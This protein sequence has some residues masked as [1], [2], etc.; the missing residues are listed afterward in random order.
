MKTYK[1]LVCEIKEEMNNGGKR[2]FSKELFSELSKAYLND[3][4]NTTTVAKTK[5]GE[6]L[7]EEVGVVDDFRKFM[8]KVLIDFGVDKQEASK[9]RTDYEFTNVDALYPVCS[10]LIMNYVDTGKKFTFLPKEDCVASLLLDEY[11]DEV[12]YNKN[13][14][15]PDAAPKATMYKKHRKLKTEST[16]PSWL[17]ELV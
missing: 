11:E 9:M 2:T 1:E 7:T 6:V 10:E 5:N 3:I 14:K 4:G 15:D 13:P 17:R 12:H 8:E 16:C